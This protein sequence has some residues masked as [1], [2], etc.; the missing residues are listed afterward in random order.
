MRHQ[1]ATQVTS[2]TQLTLALR[3]SER[4]AREDFLEGPGNS[5]ALGLIECWPDWPARV[6]LL[7][8]PK[9][10]GKS[11]LA[12]I[13]AQMAGARIVSARSLDRERVP[14]ALATGALVVENLA[15]GCFDE[16]ALFHLLNLAREEDAF[17]LLTAREAPATWPPGLPDL[18]SRLRAVPGVQLAPPDDALLHAVIVKLFADRQLTVDESLVRYVAMRIERTFAAAQAAVTILDR[19]ALQL[20]RPVTRTLA[21][22]LFTKSML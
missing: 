12:S 4:L 16:A 2:P 21:G 20:G 10:S 6:M 18:I 15:A 19:E 1:G 17:L 5:E 9:G 13:W 3:H 14:G 22:E 11:H 7:T 8:G